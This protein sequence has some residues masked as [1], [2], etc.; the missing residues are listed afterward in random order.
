[1][2][3]IHAYNHNTHTTTGY[4][5]GDIINNTDEEIKNKVILNIERSLKYN[6]NLSA[7]C[8]IKGLPPHSNYFQ[9][10]NMII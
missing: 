9:K 8:E 10:L 4:K 7:I 6:I 3:A 2:E 5:P 1:M